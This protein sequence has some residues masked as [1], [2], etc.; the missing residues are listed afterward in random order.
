MQFSG[1]RAGAFLC[2]LFLLLSAAAQIATPVRAQTANDFYKGRQLIM[3]VYS[4]PGSA[5]DIYARLLA[6]HLADH[7]PGR[8]TIVVENMEGAGGL[9]AI[10]YLYTVAP[11]DGTV[12]GTIGRGLP[13]EPILGRN[14]VNFDPLQFTWLGSMNRE[15]SLAFSWYD[16]KVKTF[17]DLEKFELLVPGTG[18]GADS[19]IIPLAVNHL[20]GTKFKIITGYPDTGAASLALERHEL[21]GIGYWAWSSIMTAHPDWVSGKKIN[22]LF[23]TG[24]GP[25]PA[26]PDAPQIRKLVD[27]PVDRQALAFLLDR[28][29]IGRPFVAPPGL[30]PDRASLLRAAFMATMHD[31]ELLKDA[32]G[33][34]LDVDSVSAAD[35]DA[36]LHQA[37]S[38]PKDVIDRVKQ[39]LERQ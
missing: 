26:A 2:T 5:Y 7:I 10:Q 38:A 1:R 20:A 33:A 30:P 39:A 13:F 28:E 36:L 6:R 32:Q 9:K 35:V 23:E 11:K 14:I 18:A 29:I 15:V 34:G 19:E 37:T 17:A 16:S 8:P 27:D 21:D 3:I 22:L 24:L 25:L 31:P 12:I 4:G